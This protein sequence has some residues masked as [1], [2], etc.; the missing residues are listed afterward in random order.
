MNALERK[1]IDKLGGYKDTAPVY[2]IEPRPLDELEKSAA[3]L[4]CRV[5]GRD[6]DG[7]SRVSRSE[8]RT[9]LLLSGGLRARAYHASG[10]MAVNAGLAPMTHLLGDKVDKGALTEAAVATAKRLGLDRLGSSGEKLTFERLWQ[11]KAAGINRES[12]RGREVV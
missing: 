8:G 10:A 11:I 3:Q 9:E 7:R 5:A 2:R 6:E 1:L 12:V 4:A